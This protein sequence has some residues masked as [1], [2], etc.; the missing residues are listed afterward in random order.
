MQTHKKQHPH[1]H[2]TD[3]DRMLS[4]KTWGEPGEQG[5]FTP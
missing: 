4:L 2:T 3:P 1:D 5:D